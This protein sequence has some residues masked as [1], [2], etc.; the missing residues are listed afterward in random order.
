MYPAVY[1]SL[2][3]VPVP[4]EYQNNHSYFH[5]TTVIRNDTCSV[6]AG[7]LLLWSVVDTKRLIIET[8]QIYSQ[9]GVN[10]LSFV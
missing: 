7:V 3:L 2:R 9:D 1:H 4:G 5:M 6:S 10:G 8:N